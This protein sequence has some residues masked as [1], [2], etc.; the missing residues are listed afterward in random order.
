M[1]EL[2]LDILANEHLV[3]KISKEPSELGSWNFASCLEPMCRWPSE[4]CGIVDYFCQELCPISVL[5]FCI[6]KRI[7]WRI[8]FYKHVS[9]LFVFFVHTGSNFNK[10]MELDSKSKQN[11]TK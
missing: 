6:D 4:I 3:S 2:V 8:V 5:A 11:K 7:V 9:V 10:N 1:V